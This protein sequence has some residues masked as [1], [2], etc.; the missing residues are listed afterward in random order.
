M[1]AV[2]IS[3]TRRKLNTPNMV[4]SRLHDGIMC[5]SMSGRPVSHLTLN[6]YVCYCEGLL[7]YVCMCGN[8]E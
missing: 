7:Y 4:T 1:I 8:S 3:W 5:K 6:A 2:E